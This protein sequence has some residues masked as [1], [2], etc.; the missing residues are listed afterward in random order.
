MRVN[1]INTIT[2]LQDSGESVNVIFGEKERFFNELYKLRNAC[3]IKKWF[4]D[5]IINPVCQ[6]LEE[7]RGSQ[8]KH[9][10]DQVI[11]MISAEYD[12]DIS[13][14]VCASRLNYHPSYIW[15]VLKKEM[16]TTFSEY[17]SSYRLSIAKDLL[18]ETDMSVGKIAEKLGYNNSQNFIRYF[19]KQEGMTP[20]KYRENLSGDL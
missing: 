8:H 17:L 13:L 16:N 14:E 19:K 6:R 9:I 3:E 15:R 11:N 2:I 1:L 18:V 4:R 7:H 20:S 12:K 5:S 10:L